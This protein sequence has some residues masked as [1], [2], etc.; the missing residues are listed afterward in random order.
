[1]LLAEDPAE[2][3]NP[4]RVRLN[5]VMSWHIRW[6]R[7]IIGLNPLRVRLNKVMKLGEMTQLLVTQSQS[8][9]STIK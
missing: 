6:S 8:S 7:R 5:K 9:A 4:L 1:M 2:C 3:L